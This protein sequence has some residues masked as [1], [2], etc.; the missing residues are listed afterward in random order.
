MQKR[1]FHFSYSLHQSR[2]EPLLH[3][4]RDGDAFAELEGLL[5]KDDYEYHGLI[6]NFPTPDFKGESPPFNSSDLIV[7]TTRPPH[8][9]KIKMDKKDY[10]PSGEEFER[11]ILDVVD[12]YLAAHNRSL[13]TLSR[14]MAARLTKPDRGEIEFRQHH[15]AHY[16]RYRNPHTRNREQA[17]WQT[18]TKE[19]L[20]AAFVLLTN[21]WKGGP[22]FLNA[23]GMDGP[24]TLIWCYL[25]RTRF[26]ELL[27]PHRFV[28]AELT[29]DPLPRRPQSLSFADD[30]KVD[31]LLNQ[32]L[33]EHESPGPADPS[34]RIAT[35][36][37]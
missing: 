8:R 28:M 34:A 1:L 7:L 29:T 16:L 14:D 4:L 26:S 6:L 21:L 5:L 36:V 11:L 35:F 30:W 3:A 27:R 9:Y 31:I 10:S 17:K 18:P 25:L 13:V 20:T 24:T 22:L 37:W 12:L 23:F 33:P 2:S 32:E 15:G 19:T